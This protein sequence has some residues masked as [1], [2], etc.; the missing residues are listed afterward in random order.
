MITT[1]RDR[2]AG[3]PNMEAT[4][5]NCGV[6]ADSFVEMECR[7]QYM[8]AQVEE[9]QSA[10]ARKHTTEQAAV[11]RAETVEKELDSTREALQVGPD[12]MGAPSR[13]T[14]CSATCPSLTPSAGTASAPPSLPPPPSS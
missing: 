10:L 14:S 13:F 2:G 8:E 7:L 3:G 1:P 9:A 12:Q 6:G 4:R 5:L 11:Q